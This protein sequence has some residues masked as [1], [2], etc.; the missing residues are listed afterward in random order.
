MTACR[1]HRWEVVTVAVTRSRNDGND[2]F[3]RHQQR[4][5]RIRKWRRSARRNRLSQR[6][7]KG[8]ER[9]ARMERLN[10]ICFGLQIVSSYISAGFDDGGSALFGGLGWDDVRALLCRAGDCQDCR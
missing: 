2:D 4:A 6:G 9:N 7:A 5:E 3:Q 1:R 10:A 8:I